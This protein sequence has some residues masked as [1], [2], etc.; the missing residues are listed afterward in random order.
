MAQE[1]ANEL[2]VIRA[3]WRWR[4]PVLAV[5]LLFGSIGYFVNASQEDEFIAT[6]SLVLEDPAATSV[7]EGSVVRTNPRFIANQLEILGS[8]VVAQ[9]ASEAAAED[10]LTIGVTEFLT[11]AEFV[12]LPTADVVIITTRDQDPER[13]GAMNQYIVDAYVD[14]QRE[15]RR[16]GA[17]T[18]LEQLADAE[19]VLVNALGEFND[20]LESLS[21]RRGIDAQTEMVLDQLAAT[22]AQLIAA[23]EPERR[24][25]L[26]ARIAEL[27]Q[28]LRTLSLASD[29]ESS[30]PEVASLLRSRDQ[31]LDRISD[32]SRRQ[33]EV[34]IDSESV[35]SVVGFASTPTVALAGSGLVAALRV[36]AGLLVGFVLA[37]TGAYIYTLL[38]RTFTTSR[39]P[40]TDLGLPYLGEVPEFDT[41]AAPIPVRDEPRGLAAESFRFVAAAVQLRAERQSV[42]SVMVVSAHVGDGKSTVLANTAM[43]AARS[44]REVLVIDA[45]FG[46]QATSQLLMGDVPLRTG[47]TELVAGQ[48]ELRDAIVEVE[49]SS[50]VSFDLLSRG[51]LPVVA[52]DFFASERVRLVLAQLEMV[53]DLVLIDGPPLMQVAY[54]GNLVQMAGG[55]VAVISHE[56]P[57]RSAEELAG[58]LEFIASPTLGYVYNR[59]PR[60]GG[61]DESGGSMKDILGD[62]GFVDKSTKRAKR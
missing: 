34:E 40:E 51:V 60:R 33:T 6:S 19:S 30:R 57:V 53:Y 31:V 13:A 46:N 3:V 26:L 32:L 20:R 2:T 5:T 4:V 49:V 11:T 55:T 27:D 7:L 23:T 61:V 9:R 42:T 62:R 12:P 18:V 25:E 44:G 50:G 29:I 47:L 59:A 28:Q 38:R 22:Q 10:G 21:G 8:P 17:E 45:D 39:Q 43:A 56:S 36:F 48:S 37:A 35:A 24:A 14:V 41:D 58:R 1:S 52:P 54:A 15:Q 16:A